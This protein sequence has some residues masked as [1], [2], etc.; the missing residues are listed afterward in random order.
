M[1]R[2]RGRQEPDQPQLV[3]GGTRDLT[4]ASD[5]PAQQTEAKW[6][7]TLPGTDPVPLIWEETYDDREQ[8]DDLQHW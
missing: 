4:P 8:A 5:L 6:A 1:I 2:W 7:A 3:N